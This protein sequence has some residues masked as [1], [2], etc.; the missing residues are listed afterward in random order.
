MPNIACCLDGSNSTITIREFGNIIQSVVPSCTSQLRDSGWATRS[1]LEGWVPDQ[2]FLDVP[3]S[4]FAAFWLTGACP[5]LDAASFT[6]QIAEFIWRT[7]QAVSRWARK[8]TATLASGGCRSGCGGC[9]TCL[10]T[11]V[12]ILGSHPFWMATNLFTHRPFA[13]ETSIR[14]LVI[15]L[16]L[17]LPVSEAPSWTW[18]IWPIVRTK[19]FPLPKLCSLLAH[20][21]T[22]NVFA[23]LRTIIGFDFTLF[24]A[25]CGNNTTGCILFMFGSPHLQQGHCII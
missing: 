24:R 20:V 14:S 8:F 5:I 6:V 12:L 25:S 23:T 16:D 11:S 13:P 9:G 10:L 3:K 17:E 4:T 2:R 18:R 7:S 1:A 15:T 21:T 19:I 22:L